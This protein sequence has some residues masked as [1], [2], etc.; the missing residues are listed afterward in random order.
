MFSGPAIQ[1]PV[2]SIFIILLAALCFTMAISRGTRVGG[3][4][5]HGK[6]E[7]RPINPASRVIGILISLVLLY[8]G[9]QG[10]MK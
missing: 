10:F 8:A 4:F 1:G 9:L 6:G 2:L 3:A 5:M 7:T